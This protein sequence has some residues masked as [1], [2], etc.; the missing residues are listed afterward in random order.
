MTT[1]SLRLFESRS[2]AELYIA[3]LMEGVLR[4]QLQQDVHAGLLLSGG[5]TPGPVYERLS[6][7]DID[8]TRV[9]VGLVDE[10]WVEPSDARSN[11]G[12]LSRTL[13]Q[14]HAA[15]A[16]FLPMKTM[17]ATPSE[18]AATLEARYGR[19]L[20]LGPLVLLGMGVDGHTASW[21]PNLRGLDAVMDPDTSQAVAAV[22]ATGS[23]V[24][25]D[26][27]HRI[28][29][30]GRALEAAN[31][32]VLYITGN[33]KRAIFDARELRCP[34]HFA[35]EILGDRLVAVWAP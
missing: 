31:V 35:E 5:S 10:R 9:D 16:H 19:H 14:N 1:S 18:G 32:A 21:F 33:D 20:D 34:V 15:S 28:T 12:L 3:A 8:W 17:D 13:F 29:V 11:A 30:T 7:A 4:L 24:A 6:R 23:Q 22:D 2:T 26:M 27:P 25:G